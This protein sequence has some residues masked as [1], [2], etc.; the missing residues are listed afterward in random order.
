VVAVLIGLG[1]P[2]ALPW[3]VPVGA[4]AELELEPELHALTVS[5]T[6]TMPSRITLRHDWRT[7]LCANVTLLE[8]MNHDV[9]CSFT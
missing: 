2:A 6:A 9:R 7:C 1:E 5:A 3:L 4:A 8:S